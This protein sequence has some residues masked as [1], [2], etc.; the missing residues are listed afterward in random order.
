MAYT[1]D[2]LQNKQNE[3]YLI[4]Q[5]FEK[6]KEQKCKEETI[7]SLSNI[8]ISYMEK[9]PLFENFKNLGI[10]THYMNIK[11]ESE[12]ALKEL[13]PKFHSLGQKLVALREECYAMEDNLRKQGLIA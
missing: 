9:D 4:L 2:Q 3:K 7:V 10:L 8:V 6:I 11:K 5:E 12:D 13:D 1:L